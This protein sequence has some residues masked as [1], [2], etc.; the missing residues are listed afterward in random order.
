MCQSNITLKICS[1]LINTFKINYM[2]F[3]N[4][5]ISLLKNI[6]NAHKY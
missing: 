5:L 1:L 2:Y 4:A 6:L 3:K